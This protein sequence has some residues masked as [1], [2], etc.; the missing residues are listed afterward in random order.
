MLRYSN[1]VILQ[2]ELLFLLIPLA[3]ITIY[4]LR[5]RF[6]KDKLRLFKS[7]GKFLIFLSK[8]IF[9][10]LIIIALSS[11]YKEY[12]DTSGNLSKIK[13]LIDRSK[14]M[15][16]Y[17]IDEALLNLEVVKTPLDIIDLELSDYS[18]LGQSI[19]NNLAPD[20]NILLITDGQ[21]NFGTDLE[22]VALFATTIN[23]KIYGLN[24][25]EKEEDA[26]ITVLGPSKVVSEVENTFTIELKE[27]GNVRKRVKIYIDDKLEIEQQYEK[28]IE[29]KKSFKSGSHVIKAEIETDDYFSENNEFFKIINV[30]KKPKLLFVSKDNSPLYDLFSDFY[31]VDLKD[32]ISELDKY[33]TVI[34]N[35]INA[36]D[37]SEKDLDNLDEYL[38]EENGL[39]VIGGKESYDWGD[40][41]KSLIVN[42][43][44]VSI[45][46]AKKKKDVINLYIVMDT[47][48]SGGEM[49][50][51][52]FSKFD[53]QKAVAVEIINS[54]SSFNKV[55]LVE[56]NYYLNTLTGLSELGPKKEKLVTDIYLMS[57]HGFS[58]LRFAY[59]KAHESLRLSR[60][61]KNIIIITDGKLIPQDQ[62]VTLEFVKKAN[63]DGI[64][65]F[66]VGIGDSSDK[67]FLEAVKEQGKG[68]YFQMD[69]TQKLKLYFGDPNE[70]STDR[71][72]TY[73]Y[74]SNHFITRDLKDLG[75]LYGF[76]SVYPKTNARLLLTTS[77]GDPILTIWN[78]GL[79][80]VAS[81]TTDDGIK[82]YP[83]MLKDINSKAVIR[84]VNWLV[85]NPERKN[86]FIIEIPEIRVNENI[87]IIV[88]SNEPPNG[89]YFED[90]KGIYLGNFYANETGITSILNTP[91]AVNYKKE[92]LN[93]GI[94]RDFEKILQITGG[95]YISKEFD[96]N[97]ESLTKIQT[98]KTKDLSW[99]FVIAGIVVY[100]T[101]IL[102]RR[103]MQL[104]IE[105]RF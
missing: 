95:S 76:N 100:L 90:S 31:D 1:Y 77:T 15:E 99:L 27:I 96:T 79:G 71:L 29:L 37:L 38:N 39:F 4:I 91:A 65:T 16:L 19:L 34:L 92:Y 36:K 78:Y 44:P 69:E 63:G 62:A 54:I 53:V 85:E 41:N 104:R 84:T 97:L 28:P 72:E 70:H 61:S 45:G 73:V 48:A 83:E 8:M 59:E 60:G 75:R 93:L 86:E 50:N 5:K 23:S 24:L 57:P 30:H 40:Y 2:P 35:N 80:R 25:N 22:D 3:I 55:G 58:E 64:K 51:D 17:D 81:L 89:N 6:V 68:E 103:I 33:H 12:E 9:F 13:V 67:E 102:I 94:N 10:T 26:V 14:S 74:D 32:D 98:L 52:E 49:I 42:L 18:S 88:K 105:R 21:N 87:Q 101:E 82:W 66:I 20:E 56:G 7:R 43:L 46:Q 47:G 11:P